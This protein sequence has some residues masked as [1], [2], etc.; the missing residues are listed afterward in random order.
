MIS[1]IITID[2]EVNMEF[3]I[4]KEL[5]RS[6]VTLATVIEAKDPYTG[7]HTWRVSQ[8]AIKLGE[9]IGLS[10][11]ELFI[12]H[13]G[14]LVHDIGKIGI[15]D[16]ILLKPGPLTDDEYDVMKQHPNIGLSLI[17]SHPLFP[18]LKDSVFL[19]HERFDGRGYPNKE[20]PP[21]LSRIA[22]ITSIADAFDAM[23]SNRPYRNGMPVEKAL[24]ILEDE[25][26]KQFDNDLTSVFI[27]LCINGDLDHI[28]GHCGD[29]RLLMTC[30]QC[31][32][33]I[34][35]TSKHGE[36]DHITCPACHGDY[37]MQ[38]LEGNMKVE[39]SGNLDNAYVP[40]VD[41]DTVNSIV[42]NLPNQINLT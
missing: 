16:A 22:M 35:P 11:D 29:D 12:V 14:G 34:A 28:L 39:F 25:K 20:I 17:S 41:E 37:I 5:I 27:D 13:L 32:P 2:L 4:D 7:G 40:L 10:E 24:L 36:G 1:I 9:K 23:T 42:L 15:N 19:H 33:I 26:G 8:Y 21:N 3:R 18:I 38:R 31:G 30:S 6:I